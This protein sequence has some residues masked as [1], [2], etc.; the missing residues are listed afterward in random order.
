MLTTAKSID[1]E[2]IAKEIRWASPLV[3]GVVLQ[4]V[5][6]GWEAHLTFDP[7]MVRARAG[8]QGIR[9]RSVAGAA[10]DPRVRKALELAIRRANARLGPERQIVRHLVVVEALVNS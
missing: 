2:T 9:D 1:H 10:A 8:Q 4:R 7:A 3:C 6:G 5:D